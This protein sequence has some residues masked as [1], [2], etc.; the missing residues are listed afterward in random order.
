[1]KKCIFTLLLAIFGFTDLPGQND[2]AAVEAVVQHFFDGLN[3][4]DTAVLQQALL[5]QARLHTISPAGEVHRVS[6]EEFI[7]QILRVGGRGLREE[8]LHQ[9]LWIDGPMAAVWAPYQLMIN[10]QF[11]HCGVNLFQLVR[12][13]G[14]WKIEAITDTRRKDNCPE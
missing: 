6:L 3:T 8:T 5:P 12:H 4:A 13:G 11:S 10:G 9:R 7:T 14:E 1:M 2:T